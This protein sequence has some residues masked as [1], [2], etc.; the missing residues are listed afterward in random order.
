MGR[1]SIPLTGWCEGTEGRVALSKLAGEGQGTR[2]GSDMAPK[3]AGKVLQPRKQG[4]GGRFALW[5]Q[6]NPMGLRVSKERSASPEL[7]IPQAAHRAPECEHPCRSA[8]PVL[9]LTSC[10]LGLQRLW[11]TEFA[12]PESAF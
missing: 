12:V 10:W 1:P 5:G 8:A 4:G 2:A 7:L 3:R 6:K 9:P 11:G